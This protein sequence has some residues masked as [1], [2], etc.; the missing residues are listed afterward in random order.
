MI[1]PF[2]RS[3]SRLRLPAR[4]RCVAHKHGT[5]DADTAKP[6]PGPRGAQWTDDETSSDAAW[7]RLCAGDDLQDAPV[8]GRARR[9]ARPRGDRRP[10]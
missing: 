2:L 7:A 9:G 8:K 5:P 4:S 3:T 6:T 10:S 1:G